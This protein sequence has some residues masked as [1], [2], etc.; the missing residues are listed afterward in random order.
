MKGA[1]AACSLAGVTWSPFTI[2]TQ[3]TFYIGETAS[4]ILK[5]TTMP[6]LTWTGCTSGTP[7]TWTFTL[8][9]STGAAYDPTIFT[10]VSS[11]TTSPYV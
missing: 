10:F 3:P 7:I 11:S 8:K 1:T 6:A 2:G 4:Y 5:D 9:T